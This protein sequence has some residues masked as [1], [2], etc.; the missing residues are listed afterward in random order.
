MDME[1]LLPSAV[2]ATIGTMYTI[3]VA[4]AVFSAK[5]FDRDLKLMRQLRNNFWVLSVLVLITVLYNGF[6]LYLQSN[7]TYGNSTSIKSIDFLYW[8]WTSF[9][10]STGLI[11]ILSYSLVSS[12]LIQIC[13]LKN[14][15]LSRRSDKLKKNIQNIRLKLDIRIK[16][17]EKLGKELR[18]F[19]EKAE[20]FVSEFKEKTS[21]LYGKLEKFCEKDDIFKSKFAALEAE[22]ILNHKKNPFDNSDNSFNLNIKLVNVYCNLFEEFENIKRDI[23][24]VDDF[25]IERQKEITELGQMF[26]NLKDEITNF[27][28]QKD[29]KNYSRSYYEKEKELKYIE[30]LNKRVTQLEKEDDEIKSEMKEIKYTIDTFFISSKI[31]RLVEKHFHVKIKRK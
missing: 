24:N 21:V 20:I 29:F 19:D 3:F 7:G 13:Y 1:Y 6:V 31:T 8:S 30:K 28:E 9:F 17:I 10:S 23:E 16:K 18:V 27:H 12:V 4:V 26:Y 2:L 11:F 14:K 22:K 25:P 15:E 5:Y